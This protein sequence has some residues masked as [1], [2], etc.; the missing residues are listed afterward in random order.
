MANWADFSVCP[1]SNSV[2]QV[3]YSIPEILSVQAINGGS[4]K[5]ENYEQVLFLEFRFLIIFC[6]KFTIFFQS[7]T[8]KPIISIELY[9]NSLLRPDAS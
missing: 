5:Y 3:R 8:A 7:K 1:K 2:E 9:Q 4:K 6:F